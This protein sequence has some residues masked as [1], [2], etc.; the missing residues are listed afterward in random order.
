MPRSSPTHIL[1]LDH[2]PNKKTFKKPTTHDNNPNSLGEHFDISFHHRIILW[3]SKQY[4]QVLR[5]VLA[6]VS[7]SIPIF[8]LC[9]WFVHPNWEILEAAN[10]FDGS[11]SKQGGAQM[12]R[13]IS[14]LLQRVLGSHV[15]IWCSRWHR[16]FVSENLWF[17]WECELDSLTHL[18][19]FLMRMG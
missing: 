9:A 14:P 6:C 1:S 11:G 2:H 4:L 7:Y 8:Y 17:I 19:M 3:K 15:L 5:H 10:R 13:R 18:G 16:I 12:R